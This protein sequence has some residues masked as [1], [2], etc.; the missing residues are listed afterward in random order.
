M[1]RMSTFTVNVVHVAP[2]LTASNDRPTLHE[3]ASVRHAIA[4][5]ENLISRMKEQTKAAKARILQYKAIFLQTSRGGNDQDSSAPYQKFVTT[6][7]LVCKKWRDAAIA[8]PR[9]WSKLR[10][11]SKDNSL[12]VEA[13][14]DW[15]GRSGS[16]PKDLNIY[17]RR[18][19]DGIAASKKNIRTQRNWSQQCFFGNTKCSF[20]SRILAEAPSQMPGTCNSLA[21]CPRAHGCAQNFTQAFEHF[22]LPSAS[23]W[24]TAKEFNP[25]ACWWKGW[26]AAPY[27]F[28]RL[29]PPSATSLSLSLS[30]SFSDMERGHA[31]VE[32]KIPEALLER[33]TSLEI[34]ANGN[35]S[36]RHLY[37]LLRD[38]RNLETL[39]LDFPDCCFD[40]S[41]GEPYDRFLMTSGGHVR[42]EV[43]YKV[44]LP[45]P[46]RNNH[47]P[48][49][50]LSAR[51][52]EL[53]DIGITNR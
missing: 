8:V 19:C 10:I 53:A 36:G 6:L 26:P 51:N 3:L 18:K 9:L 7:V 14:L 46:R 38:C 37:P 29:V 43:V 40:E 41:Y 52:P 24:S 42:V 34:S 25:G 5:E 44:T 35:L 1:S 47:G 2:D 22:P 30:D 4:N 48:R 12:T 39:V 50:G 31:S 23:G 45:L 20:A 33:L 49:E 17:S 32:L 28:S 13:L 21:F 16:I 15:F 27:F 11:D